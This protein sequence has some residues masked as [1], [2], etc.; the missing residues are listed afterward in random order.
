MTLTELSI[1][2]P[3]LVIIV[4]L[5]LTVVGLFCYKQLKYELLPKFS[6]PVITVMTVYPGASPE[7]VETNVSKPIENVVAGVEN[8]AYVRSTSTENVSFITIEFRQTA[9]VDLALQDVQRKVLAMS[10]S[11]PKEVRS[12]SVSKIALDETP[13]LRMGITSSMPS[14]DFYQFLQDDVLPRLTTASGV[15]DLVVLGGDAREIKINLNVEKLKG[16][17]LTV[18]QVASAVRLANVDVPTG[19][20]KDGNEQFVVRLA[21]KFSSLEDLKILP[22]GIS[23]SGG[24]IRLGDVA[25]VQDGIREYSRINRIDG[26]NSIGLLIIK[27]A[28]ANAVETVAAVRAEMTSLEKDFEHI[29]L[30]FDVAQDSSEFTLQAAEAVQH[31]L[32]IAIFLVA[33]VMLI[34]LHSLRNSFI[35]MIAI[36]A[37]LVSTFICMYLFGFSLNL[38]TLLALSLV[39]GILVDDS[40]VVLENIYRHLE[41]GK[42]PR[43]AALE[44]RNEIGFTALSITLV[45]VVVFFPLSVLPGVVGGIMRQFAVVTLVATL[46]SLLVSFTITPMLASRFSKVQHLT[47][48]TLMGWLSLWFESQFTALVNVYEVALRWSLRNKII[49]TLFVIASFVGAVQLVKKGYITVEFIR[50]ADRGEFSVLMELAPGSTIENTNFVSQK[51]ENMLRKMPQV[52]KVYANVGASSE[53]FFSSSSNNIS[54]IVV[55]LVPKAKRQETTNEMI[56]VVK[57]KVMEFEGIKARVNP[58]GIFGTANFTPF[59]LVISG[60]NMDSV[61]K[62][63]AIIENIILKTKGTTEVRT[64]LE[65][66]K[67]EIRLE[68]DRVKLASF[69]LS[70]A[71]IGQTLQIALQGDDNTKFRDGSTEYTIRIALDEFDKSQ[72][73]DLEKL[74]FLTRKGEQ[75]ELKQFASIKQ[76]LGPAR[77]QRENRN[78]AVT[79]FSQAVGRGVGDVAADVNAEILKQGLPRG[80]KTAYTG[81]VKNQA[82][83]AASMGMAVLAAMIFVYMIMV[84]LYDN[85]V[86]P[87]VVLFSIPLAVAGAF[88]ALGLSLQSLNIFTQLGL[89]MLVGLVAKNAILLVDFANE[90]KL[91]GLGSYDALLE[92]GKERLRP[93]LMTTVAMVIGMFP[94][95]MGGGAGTEWKQGLAWVLIGGLTS[96]MLLTLVFVPVVYLT[97]DNIIAFFKRIIAKRKPS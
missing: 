78:A 40:I 65:D 83:S 10:A 87:F 57:D 2:R 13:V 71:E 79:I 3:S 63:T 77:L 62:A 86:Y 81:D 92:A 35:V 60:S 64:T 37:S 26:N 42:A 16:F 27:Q 96:S 70:L 73:S 18:P 19:K 34:F 95:A 56:R 14:K 82:D 29:K 90:A 20:L 52:Q 7:E 94:I 53:G 45:D 12:P 58:I 48:D 8:A 74:S 1:K 44:G 39:I 93:I 55:T 72:I 6:P 24:E 66:G 59:Q 91:R 84:A 22:V 25:E 47:K 51:V 21:G 50:T 69:G 23:R 54:E 89:I 32:I 68:I 76:T 49:T 30:K 80:V 85:F 46:M 28:D 4:F 5:A 38:M 33:A 17:G 88:L 9:N 75:V 97:I 15:G 61:R 41:M 67:P 31:D 11:L 43:E 36:P